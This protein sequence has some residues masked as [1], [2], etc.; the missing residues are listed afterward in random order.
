MN[1]CAH[2]VATGLGAGMFMLSVDPVSGVERGIKKAVAQAARP[3]LWTNWLP[4]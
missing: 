2:S 3:A 4:D 1:A